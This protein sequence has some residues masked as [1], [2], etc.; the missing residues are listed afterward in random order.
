MAD[1]ETILDNDTPQEAYP[2]INRNFDRLNQE[3]AGIKGSMV[4]AS[5]YGVDASIGTN[6]A[7]TLLND[8]FAAAKSQGKKY[9]Y[10]DVPHTYQV[11]GKLT[12]A[13][14]LI[15]LGDGA[16]IKSSHLDNYYI[17][18]C[19][20]L[21]V[22]TGK[23]N[24]MV[25]DENM[26]E[27]VWEAI[28]YRKIVNVC[29]WGDSISTNREPGSGDC[30]GVSY[31]TGPL[32]IEGA[33][34]GLTDGDA[35][36]HR[37]ID[38][39]VTKF[40][41]VTFNFYN[42]AIGGTYIQQWQDVNDTFNNVSQPWVDHVQDTNADLLIIAWGMNNE[43]ISAGKEFM[44]YMDQITNYIDAHFTKKPSIAWLT[45][46]RP[47][48]VLEDNRFGTYNAQFARDLAAYAARMHGKSKGHYIIDVN[49][50]SNMKRAGKDFEHPIMQAL[51]IRDT[52]LDEILSGNYVK[53]ETDY[54]LST[55]DQ[56][57]QFDVQLKDFVLEFEVN[58]GQNLPA[59][60]ESLWLHYNWIGGNDGQGSLIIIGPQNAS[61]VG[62]IADHNRYLDQAHWGR[63]G[64]Y[65]GSAAWDN[66]TFRSIRVEKRDDILDIFLDRTRVL[67]ARTKLNNMP[68]VIRLRKN[69]G[70]M[71]TFT[72]RNLKLYE[73]VYRHYLPT[74]TE[75]EMWGKYP[76]KD[77]GT[78]PWIGGDGRVHPGSV[79]IGEVYAV[80]L[81][82]FIDDLADIRIA[83]A[84]VADRG[85]LPME[86]KITAWRT[87]PDI[88]QTASG[89]NLRFFNAQWTD[90]PK[91][92]TL[93]RADGSYLKFRPDI[94]E[95][96]PGATTL[97]AGEFA[98][99]N[100]PARNI[101]Q[102]AYA[103]TGALDASYTFTS[104]LKVG[105]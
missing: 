31:N 88:P 13:L 7:T 25:H 26:F 101:T 71:G 52:Q 27:T 98:A 16:S 85:L 20:T 84:S 75:Y 100:D 95:F 15:L 72:L 1:M 51:A 2:K 46:P 22:Y 39:L 38:M 103:Y 56:Y 77:Y 40:K 61:G 42:R 68:G 14:E 90:Y 28:Q 97:L 89:A 35:Y 47:A 99:Y 24:T 60:N 93:Q 63:Q 76:G 66:N 79:G 70:E 10:F 6:D 96:D 65:S 58:F 64:I 21:Q 44:Y 5:Y 19:N 55:P 49:K 80:A 83:A 54:R 4:V 94:N 23:Y 8:L 92:V 3:I 105:S 104:Y 9:V 17:Q 62:W 36:Y 12:G 33:R 73:G 87:R 11:S 18:I 45:T 29:V 57:L 91:V 32:F 43:T 37:L 74:L 67:R 30:F 78:K 50:V 34:D 48:M 81:K 41:N 53:N 102:I 86:Q 82:E 69:P 59:S